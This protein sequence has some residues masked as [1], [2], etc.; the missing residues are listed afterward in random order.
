LFSK[1]II[2]Y[3]QPLII[4]GTTSL[5]LEILGPFCGS[6]WESI[7]YRQSDPTGESVIFQKIVITAVVVI[8]GCF[9]ND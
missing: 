8:K 5:E 7:G 6:F 4:V 1:A 9:Q 3:D 2:I